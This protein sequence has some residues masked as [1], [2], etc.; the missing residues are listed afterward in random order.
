MSGL[1]HLVFGSLS[2]PAVAAGVPLLIALFHI[3]PWA[4]D[5]QRVR[6]IPGPFLAKF[7]D[8]WLGYVSK[9]GHRSEV[10]HE[11]HEKYGPYRN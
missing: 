2:W 3:V 5:A 8:L 4:L 10:V 6:D 9:S 7:S 1:L 11:M